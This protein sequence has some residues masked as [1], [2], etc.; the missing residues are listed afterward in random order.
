MNGAGESAAGAAAAPGEAASAE[1]PPG[2]LVTAG[3]EEEARRTSW[4]VA[5]SPGLRGGEG[6]RVI[7]RPCR[8]PSAAERQIERQGRGLQIRKGSSADPGKRHP[9][10]C[11][12]T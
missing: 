6:E 4:V 7:L 1:A 3:E 11:A 12:A 8:T 10:Q 9:H 5:T 2:E